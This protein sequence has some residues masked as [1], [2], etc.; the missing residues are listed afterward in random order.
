MTLH[1]LHGL[2]GRRTFVYGCD[3]GAHNR[4]DRRSLRVELLEHDSQHEVALAEYSAQAA[5]IHHQDRAYMETCHLES[6]PGY[7]FT[8]LNR[9]EDSVPHNIPYLCHS[10]PPEK[11]RGTIS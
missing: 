7:R 10:H 6:H 2:L 5:G 1:S 9:K 3:L 4:A 11:I 8:L